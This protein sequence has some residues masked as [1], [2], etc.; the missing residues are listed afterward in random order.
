MSGDARTAEERRPYL[1]AEIEEGAARGAITVD[2]NVL[3]EVIELAARS[4]EGVSGFVSPTKASGRTHSIV[5]GSEPRANG[6]WHEQNGIRV[7]LADGVIDAELTIVVESG[8]A[9]PGLA[10]DLQ[11]CLRASTEQLLGFRIGSLAIHV[12]DVVPPQVKGAG[13]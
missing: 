1:L 2:P 5:E 8:A 11:D 3:V 13:A 7:S 6:M 9:I 12:A 10:S 4:I